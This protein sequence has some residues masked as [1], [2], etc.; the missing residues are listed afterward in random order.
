MPRMAAT[1]AA[2][3][4][5]PLL[6]IGGLSR[7]T[8]VRPTTIRWYEAEGLLPEPARTAGGHRA[9]GPAHVARLGFLR[10][11]R[12]LGFPMAEVRGLL[13]L[14]AHPAR[15]CAGAH[16]AVL[17]HLAEVDRRVARLLALRGEL[18]RMA[19]QGCESGA[20]AECRILETLADFGHGRC[21]DPSHGAAAADTVVAPA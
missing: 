19:A 7:A 1:T 17:A 8:G 15:G 12:E 10:H 2:P 6:S 16:R 11:A 3:S 20:A 5:T 9:Y 4:P 14:A 13:D 18:A 21:A